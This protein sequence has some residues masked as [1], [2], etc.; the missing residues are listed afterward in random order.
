MGGPYIDFV[1]VMSVTLLGCGC[2]LVSAA[3]LQGRVLLIL[4]MADIKH[5][6]VSNFSFWLRP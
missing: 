1:T 3:K 5:E 4:D 6:V 2:D